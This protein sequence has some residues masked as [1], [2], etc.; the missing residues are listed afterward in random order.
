MVG[1]VGALLLHVFSVTSEG[2]SGGQSQLASRILEQRSFRKCALI[3]GSC[4]KQVEKLDA[5]C[6]K[7]TQRS[8][9]SD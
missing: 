3:C 4:G 1:I 8:E 7:V 9:G 6:R 5:E 2:R